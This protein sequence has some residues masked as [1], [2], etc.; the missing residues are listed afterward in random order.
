MK[1]TPYKKATEIHRR[2]ESILL[3]CQEFSNEECYPLII[4]GLTKVNT[5]LNELK[6]K[7][8]KDSDNSENNSKLEV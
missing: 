8:I 7:F 1:K 4:D 6:I 3:D 5:L 2:I